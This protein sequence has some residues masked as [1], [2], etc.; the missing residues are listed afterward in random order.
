LRSTLPTLIVL[1]NLKVLVLSRH[2]R[3]ECLRGL[4]AL[5]IL[6]QEWKKTFEENQDFTEDAER[7]KGGGMR[8]RGR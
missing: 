1:S 7:R 4:V 6:S 5:V 2:L 3:Y 8:K